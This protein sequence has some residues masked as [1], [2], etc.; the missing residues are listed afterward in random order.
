VPAPLAEEV[1]A[2]A[3]DLPAPVITREADVNTQPSVPKAITAL[4]E[5]LPKWLKFAS[6]FYRLHTASIPLSD[7]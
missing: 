4:E 2:L 3:Q 6:E 5:K 7:E 1:L